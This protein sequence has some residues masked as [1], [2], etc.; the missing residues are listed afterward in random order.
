MISYDIEN[1]LERDGAKK[2]KENYTQYYVTRMYIDMN[3]YRL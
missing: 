3:K 2:K 1:E